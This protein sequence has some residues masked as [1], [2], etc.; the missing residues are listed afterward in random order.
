METKAPNSYKDPYWSDLASNTEKKL[1]LPNG[2]LVSILTRGER[3]NADQVS[4]ANARTPFQIIPATRDAVLKKYGIDAYLSPQNSAEAAGLLLKESLDRNKGDVS[5]A[6]AEYHGG[7][8]QKNWGP[9]TKAYVQRVSEGLTSAPARTGEKT[10]AEGGT[11]SSFQRALAASPVSDIPQNQIAQIFEAY[12]SGQMTPEEASDFESDVNAG[13]IMLP[14]GASLNKSIQKQEQKPAAFVLPDQVL[15]AYSSGKMSPDEM[16]EL[17]KD[18][19]RGIVGIPSYFKQD[20]KTQKIWKDVGSLVPGTP[21]TWETKPEPTLGEKIIGQAET[22]AALTTGLVGGVVGMPVGAVKGIAKSILDGSFGTPEAVRMVE[23]EA[24]KASQTMTYTPRTEAGQEKTKEVAQVLTQVLPPV[25]PMLG[26]PPGAITTSARMTALP[27]EAAVRAAAPAVREAAAR[28]GQAVRAGVSRITGAAPEAAAGPQSVGAAAT[29]AA[30]QRVETAAGLPVPMTLTRGAATRDPTQLAFE[31][32]QIKSAAGGP[33][34]NRA[35]EN[36]LQALQNMD[37]LIDM[38]DAKVIELT[39][40]GDSV[41]KALSKGLA[42]AKNKTRVAYQNARNSPEANAPVNPGTKVTFD[43]DGAPTQISVLD[44]LN[45][46]PVGIPSSAVTDSVRGIAKKIGIAS[47]DANGNLVPIASTVKKMEDFRK[48]ISGI[49]RFDDN[50]GIR[51]ETILK[52]LIDAQTDPVAGPLFK[53]ARSLR[54][55]AARKF[56]NRAIVARLVKNRKNMDDPMVAAD[57]VLQR[58]IFSSSPEEITFLKRVLVTSGKD[59]QQAWKNLQGATMNYIK[60]EATKNVGS[61]S[62][63]RPLVSTAQLHRVVRGLD[64][65]G[66][67]DVIFGNKNAQIIRDLNELVQDVNTVPPGTLVNTSGTTAT[68]LAAITEAG[69]TGAFTGLPLPIA[70]GIRQLIKMKKERAIKAKIEEALNALPTVQP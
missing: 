67:L 57:K 58:S 40:T 2:L 7:T 38:T 24:L 25:V 6:A 17:E 43:I 37:A 23:Q 31:K 12:K 29:P 64:S 13:K 11:V 50:I 41:V 8:N 14:R 52:K 36:N 5:L 68:L 15:D 35:E 44:Y 3:S 34:R 16:L 39:A 54:E 60:N 59:G 47:E 56:E 27:V 9:R 1:N 48:E 51:D 28:T 69:A 4:E 65:N 70:T 49:A 55:Q 46:K 21:T 66:R 32:E 33:L 42:S 26:G 19:S 10:I 18:V 63:G 45:S 61:D 53:K 30:I 22:G 62:L 20:S